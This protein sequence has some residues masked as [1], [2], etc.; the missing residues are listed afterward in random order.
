MYR[1]D[2]EVHRERMNI[3][4]SRAA[5]SNKNRILVA[6]DFGTTYSAIAWVRATAR[7]GSQP[8][9]IIQNWP[10]KANTEDKVPT[11]MGLPRQRPEDEI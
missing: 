5:K 9:G 1:G 8:Q 4:N 6:I 10:G 2:M 3:S 7:G 11:K